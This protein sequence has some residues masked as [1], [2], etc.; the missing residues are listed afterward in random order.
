MKTSAE[1]AAE[2]SAIAV[3]WGFAS[4]LEMSSDALAQ[5][6]GLVLFANRIP[7]YG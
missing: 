6:V 1:L 2:V 4:V 7:T 5:A 3:A